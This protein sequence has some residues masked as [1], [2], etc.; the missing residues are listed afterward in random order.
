LRVFSRKRME[1]ELG[2]CSAPKQASSMPCGVTLAMLLLV[3]PKSMPT[4]GSEL[5]AGDDMKGY[6]GAGSGGFQG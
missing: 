3:V 1:R 6:Y 5:D 4:A 2:V